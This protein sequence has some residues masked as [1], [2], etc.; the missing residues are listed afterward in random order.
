MGEDVMEGPKG[1]RFYCLRLIIM[2]FHG[3]CRNEKYQAP[4]HRLVS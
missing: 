3:S 1:M 4:S 2:E